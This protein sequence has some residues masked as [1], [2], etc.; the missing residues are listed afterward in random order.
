MEGADGS[1][2]K[3]EAMNGGDSSKQVMRWESILPRKSLRVLLVESDDATRHIVTA[4]LR[5][6]NYRVAAVA[7]GMKAWEVM[8]EKK[9]IFDLVLTEVAMPTLSGIGLLTKIMG[10]EEYKN[11][12][13]IMMSSHDSVNIVLS[14]MLK[15]AVDFLVK[16]VRKNELRNL[17][18]HVWRRHC[19][20]NS[21]LNASDNTTASNQISL[22]V[23]DRSK[24]DENS[25]EKC[26]AQSSG[27][28][29]DANNESMQYPDQPSQSEDRLMDKVEVNRLSDKDLILEKNASRIA[30]DH[31]A[32]NVRE[33]SYSHNISHRREADTDLMREFDGTYDPG[34][35]IE[36]NSPNPDSSVPKTIVVVEPKYDRQ[37][38]FSVLKNDTLEG[39][40][41]GTTNSSFANEESTVVAT[42]VL[43]L[44][45][46][47]P[48]GCGHIEIKERNIIKPSVVSAFSRYDDKRAQ[49]SIVH[50]EMLNA[51]EK[52]TS[53]TYTD[54]RSSPQRN[55]IQTTIYFQVS[56]TNNEKDSLP[57]QPIRNTD[58]NPIQ[59]PQFGFLPIFGPLPY[60]NFCQG[61]GSLMQ[62]MFLTEQ[63]PSKHAIDISEPRDPRELCYINEKTYNS[64]SCSHGLVK[65]N[66][67]DDSKKT[68][69]E[70][71][72]IGVSVDGANESA[73]QMLDRSR[74]EAALLK[75]R[76]KRKDRCF[77]KKVRYHS[78][79]Q[80]AEQ[81]PRVKG[82][83][84]SQ[85]VT[86]TSTTGEANS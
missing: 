13:V 47:R 22:N 27:N 55:G 5:K 74:R 49:P 35:C 40:Y 15:G 30:N 11:V 10:A 63:G 78:R 79:K 67:I 8:K 18:Q 42:P 71:R 86:K 76:L 83:F 77:E 61:Y 34:L 4:L 9:Y 50:V 51:S 85:K 72:N 81:R 64:G 23:G 21:S 38:T 36:N 73:V 44:S 16:P 48:H 69:D 12:P 20:S 46:K 1:K 66:G 80:L 59:Y 84:V 25:D 17:W 7:D 75:F 31:Y 24:S 28:K 33:Q 68:E 53:I 43:E 14:C 82:Q 2:T 3:E 19:A 6:C 65:F 45:L 60:H 58:T 54:K 39:K 26:D 57:P 62:P 41:V 29:Q 37:C 70:T 56:S 52:N 32:A